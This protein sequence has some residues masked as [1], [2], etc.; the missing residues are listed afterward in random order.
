MRRKG[1]DCVA[2]VLFRSD[3]GN[4]PCA[5]RRNAHK[6]QD[7]LRDGLLNVAAILPHSEDEAGGAIPYKGV[8]QRTGHLKFVLTILF[9][10]HD[11]QGTFNGIVKARIYVK[12]AEDLQSYD[13]LAE[14]IVMDKFG[15]VLSVTPGIAGHAVR[16]NVEIPQYLP[17]Q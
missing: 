12:L 13:S 10:T 7:R 17:P 15:N 5:V 2:A 14:R 11:A 16:M 3:A 6:E 1:N 9:F 8:W 4:Q